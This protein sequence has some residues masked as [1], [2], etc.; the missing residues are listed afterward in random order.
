[1]RYIVWLW[2]NMRGIRLNT[3]VRILAGI[4]QVGLGLLMDGKQINLIQL[5]ETVA[6]LMAK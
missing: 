6:A 5:K 2:R 1:M 3:V 4:G